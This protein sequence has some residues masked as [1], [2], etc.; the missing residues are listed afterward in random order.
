MSTTYHIACIQCKEYLWI[1]QNTSHNDAGWNLYTAE[2]Q[3]MTD[4]HNFMRKHESHT[5]RSQEEAFEPV[6]DIRFINDHPDLDDYI[7]FSDGSKWGEL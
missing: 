5:I 1:G 7:D 2:E 3:T 6:H 4:F